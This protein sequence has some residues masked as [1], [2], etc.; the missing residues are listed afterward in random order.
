MIYLLFLLVK[1]LA[2]K[3]HKIS[4]C[5]DKFEN[6][7]YHS[8]GGEGAEFQVG[9]FGRKFWKTAIV[10]HDVESGANEFN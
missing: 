2:S 1:T 8:G 10:P 4:D 9:V 5:F 7:W 6:C 3:N